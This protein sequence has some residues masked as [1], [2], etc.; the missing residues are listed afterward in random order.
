M[1]HQESLEFRVWLLGREK[2]T[3]SGREKQSLDLISYVNHEE[4]GTKGVKQLH[5]DIGQQ[6]VWECTR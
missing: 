2:T 4:N 6:A 1:M 3:T 5:F